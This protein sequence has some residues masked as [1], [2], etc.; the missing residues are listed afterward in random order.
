MSFQIQSLV[1]Y[2]F[3]GHQRWLPFQ[4]GALNVVTGD[5]KTG[6]TALI[7]ILDYC[8][9]SEDC[10]IPAGRIRRTVSWVGVKLAIADGECFIARRL[11]I[12]PKKTSADIHYIV[13][14]SVEVPEFSD[15]RPTTNPAG[16]VNL[17]SQHAGIA[18]N[19]H[20]PGLSSSRRPLSA[21]VR[22][23]LLFCFQ[24]QA[25]IISNKHLFHKQSDEF[26]P[27]AIRDVLP[28]FLGAKDEEHVER[29]IRLRD[30][31]RQLKLLDRRLEE[32]EAI[33][34]RGLTR[35]HAL[36][37][38]ARDLGMHSGEL[39]AEWAE[40]TEAL[41]TVRS[42]PVEEDE[43][44]LL[45]GEELNELQEARER[46]I[47]D[48]RRT[49]DQLAAA[50]A[51]TTE[52]A[53]YE[54]EERE[55][56]FRLESVNLIPAPAEIE[57]LCPLCESRVPESLPSIQ[58]LRTSL[59]RVGERVRHV[60]ERSPAMDEVVRTLD[61]RL[62]DLKRQLKENS[63]SVRVLQESRAR[64]AEFRD[65]QLRGAHLLGRVSLYLENLP[66]SP[67]TTED[68]SA[69]D[70]LMRQIEALEEELS[71]DV[72]EER[73]QS[74]LSLLGRD[75][76]AWA[77]ELDLEH[78]GNPLRLDAGGLT[79]VADTDRGPISMENMGSGE[80]WVG[81]HLIA[82]LALHKRFVR[83]NSPVPRFLFMDQP[84][85]VYFSADQAVL[86]ELGDLP[87]ADRQGV[88]RMYRLMYE[89][90]AELGGELQV[91]V[92]DHADI[93]EDWFQESV[94]EHWRG[95]NALVPDNWPEQ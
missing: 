72:V 52:R 38:E 80:N 4:T 73:L 53:G 62:G 32:A 7:N 27:Q 8:F 22:H 92:T 85:Q 93:A 17:L 51:L 43:V 11:P 33:A 28:Y 35:A 20:R 18:E 50:Q 19:L 66:D 30:L 23:A 70:A 14:K 37:T 86:N 49:R 58:Q 56:F 42:T 84:S 46:I 63:E 36:L 60:E 78:S 9:G 40:A 67:K 88:M 87:D 31:K 91:L 44:V 54:R 41:T 21:N 94:V 5:S 47:G 48:M 82:H 16:I 61:Q 13:G 65:R 39:P 10:D 34:G 64:L 81:Y 15:L 74:S 24:H 77:D 6:K 89:V 95:G 2:S 25:E 29:S 69:R 55:Q 26:V 1:L 68:S 75:M 12:A 57:H 90:V 79:I 76:T 83:Q 59:E 71:E 3:E 45:E